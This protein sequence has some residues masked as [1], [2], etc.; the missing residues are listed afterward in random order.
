MAG[1]TTVPGPSPEERALQAAQAEQLALQ[2]QIL[3][4]QQAQNQTLLPFLANLE[5]FDVT[6]DP[7][8]GNIT[9][10]AQRADPLKEQNTEIQR[11]LNERSLKALRGEL[12]VDPALEE[13]I[14]GGEEKL[15]NT[16][17]ARLGPGY[18]TSSP[19]IEALGDFFKN[20]TLARE[21]ARTGQLTLAEQLGL[22]RQQQDIFARGSATDALRTSAVGDPMTFAG[23]Y[24]QVAR[25]YGQAQVPFLQQ[26]GLQTQASLANM[27][28]GNALIGAGIGAIGAYFSDEDIKGDLIQISKTMEGI[29]IYVYTRKDTD[30]RLIGVLSSDVE[31]FYPG[32][33]YEKGGYEMVDYRWVD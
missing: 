10:I 3:K 4:N 20:A 19:G 30:E 14:R 23:G 33:I 13:D 9:N 25:G 31:K 27:Q 16:L 11:L 2:T 32:A 7:T 12:D 8:T 22:T 6:L 24:G 17:L 15:R 21:G 26:R 18:D 5:G 29:P 1:K 28:S